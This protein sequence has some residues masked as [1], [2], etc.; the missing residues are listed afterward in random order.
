MLDTEWSMWL[1][2]IQYLRLSEQLHLGLLMC[3][4]TVRLGD[5][6]DLTVSCDTKASPTFLLMKWQLCTHFDLLRSAVSS[7]HQLCRESN[8]TKS[9]RELRIDFLRKKQFCL[10]MSVSKRNGSH[11]LSP[12][13][14]THHNQI[15]LQHHDQLLHREAPVRA[16]DNHRGVSEFIPPGHVNIDLPG[17]DFRSLRSRIPKHFS[18]QN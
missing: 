3:D 1:F 18:L 12:K 15:L 13:T 5:F 10:V 4:G 11:Q 7:S 14:Q 9:V 17:V 8:K 16:H 2:C 6:R